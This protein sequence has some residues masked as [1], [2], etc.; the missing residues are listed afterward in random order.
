[1]EYDIEGL[2]GS[3]HVML[4]NRYEDG[5]LIEDENGGISSAR[6]PVGSSTS[7]GWQGPRP[8][9]RPARAEA[10]GGPGRF[11]RRHRESISMMKLTSQATTQRQCSESSLARMRTKLSILYWSILQLSRPEP[12]NW[13]PRVMA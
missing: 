4:I 6:L 10:E 11:A 1:M 12:S 9:Q 2:V 5:D 3:Q 7:W 13:L 8:A